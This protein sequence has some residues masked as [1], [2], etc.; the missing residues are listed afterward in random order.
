MVRCYGSLLFLASSFHDMVDMH[1]V[2]TGINDVERKMLSERL[3]QSNTVENVKGKNCA[4][5]CYRI[6]GQPKETPDVWVKDPSRSIVLQ[7][8]ALPKCHHLDYSSSLVRCDTTNLSMRLSTAR[9]FRMLVH[10]VTLGLHFC[11]QVQADVRT[12]VSKTFASRHS[13]RF[14]RVQR[15]RWDKSPLDIQTD[16]DLW[17]IVESNKGAIVGEPHLITLS[18][19]SAHPCNA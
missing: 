13:L 12:I 10:S 18:H 6:T 8:L 2:G 15:V 4:P 14:P 1:R 3:L 7:V 17:Q 5:R 16:R 19:L 11:L 9:V